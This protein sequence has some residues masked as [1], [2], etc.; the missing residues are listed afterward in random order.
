MSLNSDQSSSA[1]FHRRLPVSRLL[2]LLSICF[3]SMAL[4]SGCGSSQKTKAGTI[5]VTYPSGVTQGQLPVL[6]AA[7]VSMMPVNDV[8]NLGVDW[9]LTCGGNAQIGYTT[10]GCGTL[11]PS[12]TAD[13]FP[14]SYTAPN[15]IPAD[16]TITIT[17]RVT[18]D[19]S[20]QSSVTLTIVNP[21]ISVAMSKVPAS[22]AVGGTTNLIALVT[23]DVNTLGV[24]W[25]TSI[26]GTTCIPT[27][28]GSFSPPQTLSGVTT[29]YTAPTAVPQGGTVTLT[30]TSVA[31][32]T[33]SA[34][35]TITILPI[36]V[37]VSPSTF[38][39][40]T[41][42]AES[43]TA[44]V[45]NDVKNAG[46]TW[47][48]G[49]TGCGNF[50]PEQTA[51][52]SGTIYTAPS[53]VPTGN[54]VRITATS[55]NDGS[56]SSYAVATV[57][58][59]PVINVTMTR[60]VPTSLAEGKT[61]TL[62]ATVSGDS[63]GVDWIATCG[64]SAPGACGTFNPATTSSGSTTIYT[65]PSSLPPTNPVVITA[66]S[67]AYDLNPAL[68]AN[69]AT[70][71]TSI[72]VPASIAYT[73]QPPTSVPTTGQATIS[74]TV[75]NDATSGGGC[76]LVGCVQ[77]YR[78]GRLRVCNSLR[79][80][81]R[82]NGHLCSAADSSRCTGTNRCR[83]DGVSS[84]L[85]SVN[86]GNGYPVDSAFDRLCSFCPIAAPGRDNGDAQ[87]RGHERSVARWR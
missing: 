74:A 33:K 41:S 52:G 32:G 9:T 39:I 18:S 23:N 14:A 69:A 54:P 30:A 55:A 24:N 10:T 26:D 5:S 12:H 70:E 37:S 22:L 44:V 84:H 25:T 6:S 65:A 50:S 71:S 43:L 34:S 27:I 66:T 62:G 73:E 35:W 83:L 57:T 29:A 47:N 76:H 60:T 49:F 72:T 64:S 53:T 28:C 31:D 8:A 11:V 67:H 46:V 4:L 40:A 38:Y 80:C 59:S 3:S 87:R 15:T 81:R 58:A 63:T 17:A 77:Q 16:T 56:T 45:A 68:I 2:A 36:T 48:C 51:S 1:C 61:A 82:G 21:L 20:Q 75:T 78:G 85:R 86:R 42:G 79:N 7:A 19:P 13:G